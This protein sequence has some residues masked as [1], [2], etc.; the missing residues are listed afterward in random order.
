[1]ALIQIDAVQTCRSRISNI[2]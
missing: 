1:M 2:Q